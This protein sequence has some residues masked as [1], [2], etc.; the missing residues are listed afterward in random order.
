MNIQDTWYSAFW[1]KLDMLKVQQEVPSSPCFMR[2]QISCAWQ[3]FPLVKHV[4]PEHPPFTLR[5]TNIAIEN[6]NL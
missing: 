6:S 1:L 2:V 5:Q 3:E 4:L